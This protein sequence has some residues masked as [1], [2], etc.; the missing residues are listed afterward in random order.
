MYR[1]VIVRGSHEPI[2]CP[3]GQL[4]VHA[5]RTIYGAY[6]NAVCI[7]GGPEK[8]EKQP[9]LSSFRLTTSAFDGGFNWWM[10]HSCCRGSSQC[11]ASTSWI[12]HP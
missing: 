1:Q 5:A 6:S 10:Q 11:V 2:N 12:R 3:N 8:V 7:E 9:R 4:M